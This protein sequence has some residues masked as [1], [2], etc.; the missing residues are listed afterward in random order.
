[1]RYALK[2]PDWLVRRRRKTAFGKMEKYC[3]GEAFFQVEREYDTDDV[4]TP[5]HT[6]DLDADD[7]LD[8]GHYKV[9]SYRAIEFRCV[10]PQ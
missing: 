2:G 9:E 7:L 4:V 10:A 6:A 1:V 8:K 5:Y 3:E